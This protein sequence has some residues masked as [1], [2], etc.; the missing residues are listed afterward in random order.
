MISLVRSTIDS[1][2]IHLDVIREDNVLYTG[3]ISEGKP[4]TA[5]LMI[6]GQVAFTL[7]TPFLTLDSAAKG[8]DKLHPKLK[9]FIQ[10]HEDKC[11]GKLSTQPN[12]FPVRPDILAMELRGSFF[13][14]CRI[15][16][17]FTKNS[18]YLVLQDEAKCAYFE[19][20]HQISETQYERVIYARDSKSEIVGILMALTMDI[21]QGDKVCHGRPGGRMIDSFV[22]RCEEEKAND[23]EIPDPRTDPKTWV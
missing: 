17:N 16:K 13:D 15:R 5:Q 2:E 18:A 1:G 20:A 10:D 21:V 22:T 8:Y 9:F 11:I 12:F 3:L 7:S 14:C 19:P 4:L 23:S 6:P